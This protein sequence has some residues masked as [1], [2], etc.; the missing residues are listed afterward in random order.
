V[1]DQAPYD[2]LLLEPLPVAG[3]VSF[4]P[5]LMSRRRRARAASRHALVETTATTIRDARSLPPWS[6]T[7]RPVVPS[8]SVAGFLPGFS[9]MID[10]HPGL[11]DS[12]PR[13]WRQHQ[14]DGRVDVAH[15]LFLEE[16]RRA[17]SGT[18][19][20]RGSLRRPGRARAIPVELWL[21]PRL[22]AWTRLSVE[23]ERSVHVSRRYFRS[24]HRVLD[25]LAARLGRELPAA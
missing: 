15:H 13:W 21:W 4:G 16:P 1:R 6:G 2:E 17:R 25:A 22:D 5:A 9:R 3:V 19:R 10:L 23:P 11:L 20:M 24:G 18:W 14:R 12:L 8:S 7:W